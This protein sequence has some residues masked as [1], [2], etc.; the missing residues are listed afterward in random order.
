MN[1]DQWVQKVLPLVTQII[2]ERGLTL[3]VWYDQ[4]MG[5][6]DID[7]ESTGECM[8]YATPFWECEDA[9]PV[10]LV[11]TDGQV[12]FDCD[13]H[14]AVDALTDRQAAVIYVDEM[15]HVLSQIK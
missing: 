14:Y 2:E 12:T 13:V 9:V 8:L 6:V 1:T 4:L 15:L 11:N 10:Q 5:T 3:S 7:H